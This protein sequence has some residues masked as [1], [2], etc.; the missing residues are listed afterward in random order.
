[1]L[2]IPAGELAVALQELARTTGVEF[3]YSAEQLKD[4]LV[5]GAVNLG[6]K[7]IAGFV[8]LQIFLRSMGVAINTTSASDALIVSSRSL[9]CSAE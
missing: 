6:R 3:I 2:G 1:M 7:R 4:R 5:A 9:R 8:R